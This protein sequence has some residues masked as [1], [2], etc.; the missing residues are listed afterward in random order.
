[1]EEIP[2]GSD[3]SL[4]CG[5]NLLEEVELTLD[6]RFKAALEDGLEQSVF[7][8]EMVIESG[9]VDPGFGGD[10]AHGSAFVAELGEGGFGGIEDFVFRVMTYICLPMSFCFSILSTYCG[11]FSKRYNT[12]K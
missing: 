6:H 1:M 7:G 10:E 8:S 9:E 12:S 5:L 2:N 3:G 11:C 4:C